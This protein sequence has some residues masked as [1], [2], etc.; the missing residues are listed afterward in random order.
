MR[1]I[2][3]KSAF[4]KKW[5]KKNEHRYFEAD[6]NAAT[7]FHPKTRRIVYRRTKFSSTF[8]GAQKTRHL[9]GI[10]YAVSRIAKARHDVV[11]FV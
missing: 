8:K 5:H 10:K 6:L 9:Q 2:G 1:N 4:A 3:K 11:F 7:K